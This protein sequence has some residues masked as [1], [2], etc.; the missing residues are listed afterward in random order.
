MNPIWHPLSVTLS[1]LMLSGCT[2]TQ[3]T[4]SAQETRLTRLTEEL[5]QKGDST[6]VVMLYERAAASMPDNPDILLA[7]GNA[8]LRNGNPPAAEKTFRRVYNLRPED[9]NAILG[10]GYAAL[11]RNNIE[12]AY[13][14]ISSSAPLVNTYISYNLLGVTATFK[15]NFLQAQQAFSAAEALAPKNLEIK[16]NQALAYAL[17]NDIPSAIHHLSIVTASPLAE[18]H[19]IRRQA[20]ILVLAGEDAQAEKLLQGMPKQE[21]N[22]LLSQAKRI[23]DISEPTERASAIGIMPTFTP[24]LNKNT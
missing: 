16:S 22:A 7:L 15:G 17:N 23:R 11:L 24:N 1:L 4:Q 13:T 3:L 2:V 5:S 9:P 8:Q 10:L 20:L 6:S 14:L 19:H 12:R 21:I 18:P